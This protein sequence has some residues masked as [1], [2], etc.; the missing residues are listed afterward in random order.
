MIEA[1]SV[2]L[3]LDGYK[4][5]AVTGVNACAFHWLCSSNPN[6]I[7][8]RVSSDIGVSV[9]PNKIFVGDGKPFEVVIDD[10]GQYY[11]GKWQSLFDACYL[12]TDD[13]AIQE[14]IYNVYHEGGWEEF[15]SFS[16]ERGMSDEM[17]KFLTDTFILNKPIEKFP[18]DLWDTEC[19][20]TKNI[21]LNN[22][23]YGELREQNMKMKENLLQEKLKN[24][25]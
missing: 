11:V 20:I 24:E 14:A 13:S 2:P 23:S 21:Q 1:R 19:K 16:K 18:V 22:F 7:E 9:L 8:F 17:I 25:V 5:T 4:D 15:L 12:Y 10:D 6:H 3:L